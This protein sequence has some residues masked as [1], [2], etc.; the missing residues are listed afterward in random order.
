MTA[1]IRRFI[2]DCKTRLWTGAGMRQAILAELSRELDS[3]DTHDFE[4]T[5]QTEFLFS[6]TEIRFLAAKPGVNELQFD[7]VLERLLPVLDGYRGEHSGRTHRDF[8]FVSNAGLRDIIE[9]DYAELT[10]KLF[11]SE[12]WKSTIV[13]AGSLLEAILQDALGAPATV[14][15]ATQSPLAPKDS[16]GRAKELAKGEWRLQDLI[17]V[18]ADISVLPRDRADSI[19]Q[20]LRDYRNFV[21]PSKELRAK[22][23]CGKAEAFLAVGAVESILDHLTERSS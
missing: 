2:D 6:R 17:A 13:M 21:H 23:P 1:H 7:A 3:L 19:D 14:L 20:I 16:K 22:H 12:A 10:F 11:P 8:S 15:R 18:A 9:R 4:P 5:V